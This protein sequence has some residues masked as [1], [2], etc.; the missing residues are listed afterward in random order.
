MIYFMAFQ[1][2]KDTNTGP[3]RKRQVIAF[4]LAFLAIALVDHLILQK[5]HLFEGTLRLIER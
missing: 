1:A 2:H 3:D 4:L 5:L